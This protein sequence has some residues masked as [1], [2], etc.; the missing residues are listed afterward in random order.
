MNSTVLAA[1]MEA[2]GFASIHLVNLSTAVKMFVNPHFDLLNGPTK[3][4]P[5]VEK[6]HVIGMV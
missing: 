3:S 5:H 4:S 6:G 2:A 1:M